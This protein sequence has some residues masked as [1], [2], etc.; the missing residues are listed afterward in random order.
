MISVRE[1]LFDICEDEKVFEDGTDLFESGILDSYGTIEL[2]CR[3]EDEG[4]EI[5]ITR[6]DRNLLRTVRGIESL[7]ESAKQKT[8]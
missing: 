8:A 5:Q 6:I 2:L 7:I 3:L 1:I 4:V